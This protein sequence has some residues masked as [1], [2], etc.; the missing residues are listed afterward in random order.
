M[1][2]NGERWLR[3]A[4]S[5]SFAHNT[6]GSEWRMV[7]ISNYS[8]LQWIMFFGKRGCLWALIGSFIHPLCNPFSMTQMKFMFLDRGTW[9]SQLLG[10]SAQFGSG[11]FGSSCI[12]WPWRVR[13]SKAPKWNEMYVT[14]IFIYTNLNLF[15]WL[16]RSESSKLFTFN[17]DWK[18]K[19]TRKIAILVGLGQCSKPVLVDD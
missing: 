2:N 15:L 8:Y 16:L 12:G 19:H 1:V 3:M 14:Y 13:S 7:R 11:S 6:N 9:D 4:N 10:V 17:G 5:G 18:D